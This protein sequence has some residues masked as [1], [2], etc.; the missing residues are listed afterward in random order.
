MRADGSGAHLSTHASAC[1]SACAYMCMCVWLLAFA[2]VAVPPARA[3]T[4]FVSA[5]GEDAAGRGANATHALRSLQ[6]ALSSTS[7]ERVVL[8]GLVVVGG[9]GGGTAGGAVRV[10]RSVTI[11][12]HDSASGIE[13]TA[14][15]R[16]ALHVDRSA[17]AV[18]L[19]RV[20]MRG[21]AVAVE[22][23]GA[24]DELS[25][26]VER[27][28]TRALSA[29]T[30]R[31]D[32]AVATGQVRR[33]PQH[34][35]TTP[36]GMVVAANEGDLSAQRAALEDLYVSTNGAGWTVNT[37]WLTNSSEC[38]WF[39]VGCDVGGSVTRLYVLACLCQ[40]CA[41]IDCPFGRVEICSATSLRGPSR[42][43]L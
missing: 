37:G 36:P 16:T 19:T 35:S 30:E 5:A 26:R 33:T 39:G 15:Q 43:P 7:A 4:V 38:T 21:C 23:A 29:A 31:E 25:V 42:R 27:R 2:V 9:D 13:C 20:S 32:R 24:D 8:V 11:A 40:R 18:E 17:R 41:M 34:T 3:D 1:A 6:Y 10:A 12:A 14:G 22:V 28:R